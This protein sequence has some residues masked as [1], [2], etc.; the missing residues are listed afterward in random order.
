MS[1]FQGWAA[2]SGMVWRVTVARQMWVW[3]GAGG[4]CR[5]SVPH[6]FLKVKVS[7]DDDVRFGGDSKFGSVAFSECLCNNSVPQII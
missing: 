6:A 2:L 3:V 4:R 7:N 5:S 1:M